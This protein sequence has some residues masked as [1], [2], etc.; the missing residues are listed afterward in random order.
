MGGKSI[1]LPSHSMSAWIAF[2]LTALLLGQARPK[3]RRCLQQ[4]GWE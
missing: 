2:L 4:V 3:L 1:A